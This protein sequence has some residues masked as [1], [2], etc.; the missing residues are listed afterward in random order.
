M[1]IPHLAIVTGCL[2]ADNNPN[3]LEAIAPRP[4][5]EPLPLQND[6]VRHHTT[7]L[8][9]LLSSIYGPTFDAKH[10]PAWMWNRGRSKRS[11]FLRICREYY[12]DDSANLSI[13]ASRLEMGLGDWALMTTLTFVLFL[14][15]CMSGFFVA[16]YTPE[17]GLSCRSVTFLFYACSQTWLLLLWI[18]NFTWRDKDWR[19]R[20]RFM[21]ANVL[22][23]QSHICDVVLP[24]PRIE[25]PEAGSSLAP[26]SS[27]K[28]QKPAIV[29][30]ARFPGPPVRM[31][32][33]VSLLAAARWFPPQEKIAKYSVINT[34]HVERYGFLLFWLLMGLGLLGA[35][36][37]AI[38]GTLM[39]IIGVYRNCLC[40]L[41]T[42]NWWYG[43][44]EAIIV[45][46]TNSAQDI[47]QALHFWIPMGCAATGFLALV[48]Y[49]AW[50]YQRRL[51]ML[52]GV[53]VDMA[54]TNLP[55]RM[56][57]PA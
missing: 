51:R 32:S 50:W 30:T 40:R 6:W 57:M 48:T 11:W 9:H 31:E 47:S 42:Q 29:S 13:L 37:S 38:G 49:I 54:G 14:L 19:E 22:S 4:T 25:V 39:Q 12:E 46:S 5:T 7:Y 28:Q 45:I 41:T 18:W 26:P 43:R 21:E 24:I 53:L 10:K 33:V 17:I 44:A 15:P 23:A 20:P 56:A 52:F 34:W 3:S 27:D 2:L 36:F 35:V 8:R 55:E 1:S 16:Y